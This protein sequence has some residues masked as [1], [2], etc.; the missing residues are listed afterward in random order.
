MKTLH[1]FLQIETRYKKDR[2][3]TVTNESWTQA[4][5]LQSGDYVLLSAKNISAKWL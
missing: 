4:P 3:E 5:V 1:R 2:Y